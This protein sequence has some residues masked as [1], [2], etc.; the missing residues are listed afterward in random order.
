M[1]GQD[2]VSADAKT[3]AASWIELSPGQSLEC[4]SDLTVAESSIDGI[5]VDFLLKSTPMTLPKN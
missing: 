4:I 1:A 3:L 2:A 5:P